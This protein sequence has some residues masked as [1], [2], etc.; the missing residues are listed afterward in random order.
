MEKTLSNLGFKLEVQQDG[1]WKIEVPHFR[2]DVE[3]EAD[4][5]E[6]VAR[7]YGYDK[8]PAHVPPLRVFEHPSDQRRKNINKLRHLLFHYG[9]D[10]VMNFSFSEPDEE[11]RFQ[12]GNKAVEIRNPFS[13]KASMLK[14]T[15]IGG[16]LENV[17]WN[18]NRGAEGVHIFEVGNIYYWENET[19]Q[20]Q[21][22]LALVTTGLVGMA[23]WKEKNEE[24]D[25][26]RVKGTLESL[27]AH[28]RHL[29]FSF[30]EDNHPFFEPEYSLALVLKEETV[31]FFGLLKKSLLHSSLQ[32]DAV[33]AAE[34]NLAALFERQPQ[35]FHY[36]PVVRFPSIIR[37][38]SFIA[39][40]SVSYNVI[41]ETVEKLSI[42]HLQEFG[43]YDCFSG[44]SIPKDKVGLSFRLV[45]SH[46][47]RTLVTKEIDALQ[48]KIIHTFEEKLNFQLREGGKIDK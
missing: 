5:V 6:E 9:F 8:I 25:F 34:I 29:P 10:E 26:F 21:L 16:L 27:M 39:D 45:Y 35:P 19:T 20:E 38:I 11:S 46:P 36:T 28:L 23:N 18:K 14:T 1:I 17:A 2:V 44:A 42:P 4:L 33:W 48:Q 3:R 37:D 7:F 24:T 43:L 30:K 40:R 41:K 32:E 47:Q 22:T 15:L 12:T 31:G 13:S